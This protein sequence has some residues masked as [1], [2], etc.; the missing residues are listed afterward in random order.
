SF[1]DRGTLF[2]FGDAGGLP[3]WPSGTVFNWDTAPS[4]PEA[5]AAS[6]TYASRFA[7]SLMS[8]DADVARFTLNGKAGVHLADV[9]VC[10]ED[11][12]AACAS[13][14]SAGPGLMLR[15]M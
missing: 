9:R 15:R 14:G 11:A 10:G 4:L 1:V 7:P 13:E 3:A 8:S 12:A 6:T 5:S 2:I